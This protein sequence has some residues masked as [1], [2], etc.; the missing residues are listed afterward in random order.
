MLRAFR[1]K[2]AGERG[3]SAVEFAIVVPV[4]LLI[5][6]G[7]LEFAFLLRDYLSVSSS[8][9]VG[10]RVASAGAGA[11]PAACPIPLPVGLT[12]ATT[13]TPQLAKSAADA[14]QR[15]GTAMPQ[16]LID[17]IWVY[18]AN[19]WGYPANTYWTSTSPFN[20]NTGAQ[21]DDQ[22]ISNGCTTACVR[23]R[24]NEAANRFDFAGGSWDSSRIQACIRNVDAVGVYMRAT[25]PFFTRFFGA[26]TTMRDR[27]VMS[28]EPLPVN[29][30]AP[31][32]HV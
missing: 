19:Q 14:I 32:D 23:Y 21:N 10:T 15:A 13:D 25:H 16:D 9:R 3:A 20:L 12:C 6:L 31:G 22:L 18:R 7:I 2:H 17:E 1:R 27:S 24:W 30:C 4:L 26:Q 11:G 28:F 8:V 29:Q 5:L